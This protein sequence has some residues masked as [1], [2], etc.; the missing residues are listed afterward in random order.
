MVTPHPMFRFVATANSSGGGDDSGLY[1][2]VIRQNL[3]LMDRFTALAVDYLDPQREEALLKKEFPDFTDAERGNMVKYAN[4]IRKLFKGGKS[5]YV[6]NGAAQ[7][8]V[9]L[10]TRS[11]LRWGR[12]AWTYSGVRAQHVDP[13]VMGLMRAVG[14]KASAAS[15]KTLKE[16]YQRVFDP[17]G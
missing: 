13:F 10:S 9:T 8:E 2:G 7:I 3:A 5:E 4:E 12:I 6:T 16:I 17:K 14:F 1:P 11:L 15:Q